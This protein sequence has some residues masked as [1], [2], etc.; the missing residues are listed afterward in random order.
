LTVV[1]AALLLA[2]PA[3]SLVLS[4]PDNRDPGALVASVL[5]AIVV[6]LLVVSLPG[7]VE[8]FD[9]ADAWTKATAIWGVVAVVC[10]AVLLQSSRR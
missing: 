6:G 4:G 9:V 8:P 3:A 1:G 2:G 10:A 5:V 7:G